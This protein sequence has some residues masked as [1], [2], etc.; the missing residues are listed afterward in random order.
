MLTTEIYTLSLHDALPD[1]LTTI[2][3][4][5]SD[6]TTLDFSDCVALEDLTANSCKKLTTV[7]LPSSDKLKYI[8]LQEAQIKEI[9]LSNHAALTQV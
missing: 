6:V 8:Y 1:L 2:D 7:K 4:Q 5:Q 3:C 9:D